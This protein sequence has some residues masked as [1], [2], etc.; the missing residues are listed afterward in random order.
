[1]PGALAAIVEAIEP[2]H[3]ALIFEPLPRPWGLGIEPMLFVVGLRGLAISIAARWG[4][5]GQIAHTLQG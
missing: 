5:V 3:K 4:C 2:P 1:M